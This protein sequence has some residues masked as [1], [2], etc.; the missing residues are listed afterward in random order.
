MDFTG[1]QKISGQGKSQCFLS[2]LSNVDRH[3]YNFGILR[4]T[5]SLSYIG[6]API[7][8]TGNSLFW[9]RSHVPEGDGLLNISVNGFK[10]KETD[11]LKYVKNASV[12]DLDQYGY[13]YGNSWQ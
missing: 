7:F 1:W 3:F 13:R 8:D 5:R 6:M 2:D 9:N 11:L 10:G 12:L 4:D